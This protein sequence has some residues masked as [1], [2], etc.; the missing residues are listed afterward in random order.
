M[1]QTY[2]ATLVSFGSIRKVEVGFVDGQPQERI[3]WPPRPAAG[4]EIVWELNPYLAGYIYHEV[5]YPTIE[6]T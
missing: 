1:D 6:Y 3:V 4:P 2:T 5:G